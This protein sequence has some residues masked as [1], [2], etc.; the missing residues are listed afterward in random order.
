M[1]LCRLK[2]GYNKCCD[3]VD[4]QIAHKIVLNCDKCQERDDT[5]YE[6]IKEGKTLFGKKYVVIL[7]DGVQLKVKMRDVFD[8]KKDD[9]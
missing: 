4:Y 6:I 3:C 1:K 7:K 8:I 9:D 2:P 5:Y